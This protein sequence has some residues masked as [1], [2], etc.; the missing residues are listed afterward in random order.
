MRAL[1]AT[2]NRR[3]R[4]HSFAHRIHLCARQGW[5]DAAARDDPPPDADVLRVI[6]EVRDALRRSLKRHGTDDPTQRV[7]TRTSREQEA[8]GSVRYEKEETRVDRIF[9][10]R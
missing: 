3:L 7:L 1:R 2:Q 10:A 6:A 9:R 5:V 8:L 4:R